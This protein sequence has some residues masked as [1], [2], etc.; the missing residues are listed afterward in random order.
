MRTR[1]KCGLQVRCFYN[2]NVSY[3][4]DLFSKN[5]PNYEVTKPSVST[6]QVA[7]ARNTNNSAE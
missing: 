7:R 1:K 4:I 6:A 2:E 3:E 5:P